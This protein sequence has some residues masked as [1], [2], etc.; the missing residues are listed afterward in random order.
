MALYSFW[1]SSKIPLPSASLTK[2]RLEKLANRKRNVGCAVYSEL[3]NKRVVAN[4]RV[5]GTFFIH[6]G[7]W[8]DFFFICVGENACRWEKF[9]K[10]KKVVLLII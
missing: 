5:V 7:G 3:S 6:V 2:F 8:D 1:N 4:K 10:K 9:L